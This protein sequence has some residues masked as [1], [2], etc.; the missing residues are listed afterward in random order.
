MQKKQ[1]TFKYIRNTKRTDKLNNILSF[2]LH[3][4]QLD[5][6]TVKEREKTQNEIGLLSTR[7][8]YKLIGIL[9]RSVN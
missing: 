1:H 4:A 5:R 8:Y 9:K 2:F 6:E 7:A 3:T